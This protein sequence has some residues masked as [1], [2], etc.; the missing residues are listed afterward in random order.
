[1][2]HS[3]GQGGGCWRYIKQPEGKG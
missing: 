1:M 3:G 2:V